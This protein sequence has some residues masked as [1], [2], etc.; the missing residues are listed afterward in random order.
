MKSHGLEME[1]NRGVGVEGCSDGAGELES[2]KGDG[3]TCDVDDD[4]LP[5]TGGMILDISEESGLD[6]DTWEGERND[7]GLARTGDSSVGVN[8]NGGG[9]VMAQKGATAVTAERATA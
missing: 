7:V 9:I 3:V 2:A 6:T 4:M 8:G 1:D 5:V